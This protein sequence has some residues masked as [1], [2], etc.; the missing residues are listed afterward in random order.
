MVFSK[1][2]LD[3]KRGWMRIVEAFIA[4]MLIM[5]VMLVVIGNQR[6]GMNTVDEIQIKEKSILS[7]VTSDDTLRSEILS[8]LMSGTNDKVKQLVPVGYNYTIR[9][10]TINDICG[11]NFTLPGDVY[12]E[13][14]LVVANLTYYNPG[15]AVKLKLFFWRG[16]YPPG[17]SA[18][19]YSQLI[20]EVVPNI[21]TVCGDGICGSGETPFNCPSDCGLPSAVVSVSYTTPIR[22]TAP[23]V[24]PSGCAAAQDLWYYYNMT[25]QETTGKVSATFGSRKRCYYA[26]KSGSPWS[27]CD[28]LNVNMPS[29]M[30]TSLAAGQSIVVP[31]RYFCLTSGYIYNVTETFYNDSAGLNQVF[32]Y[33]VSNVN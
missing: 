20:T 29:G 12:S 3:D 18:P 5:T 7:L 11:L 26:T 22:H 4:V 8:G 10:C 23:D 21:T 28:T 13:E 33:Q 15:N 19:N 1:I 24:K 14:T 2:L 9:L 6:A 25:V 16:P 17:A 30:P 32:T 27:S 31:N